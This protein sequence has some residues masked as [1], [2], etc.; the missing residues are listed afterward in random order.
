M[1]KI[2]FTWM[3]FHLLASCGLNAQNVTNVTF[4][5]VGDKAI[6]NYSLDKEADI[7]LY[8]STNE[9]EGWNTSFMNW[10]VYQ[11][12]APA[13]R[14]VKGDVGRR[15]K[16]GQNKQIVW[17]YKEEIS[18]FFGRSEN[19]ITSSFVINDKKW[20]D[21]SLSS[22]QFKVEACPST[23]EPDLVWIDG[24][25]GLGNYWIGR[26]P[27]TIY[28]YS[29]FIKETHYITQAEKQGYAEIW[30]YTKNDF[31]KKE[32]V[33]WKCDES[34]NE[35]DPS[36]YELY[37]VVNVSWED[38]TAYCVWLSEKYNKYYDLPDIR[39]W[40]EACACLVPGSLFFGGFGKLK[41]DGIQERI[42][43]NPNEIGWFD[44]NSSK[45]IHPIGKKRP[46]SLH[47]YDMRG[48]VY[49]WTA[50]PINLETSEAVYTKDKYEELARSNK[51]THYNGIGGSS[52]EPYDD[53]IN[54]LRY[55]SKTAT[56]INIGFRVCMT[57]K[58][59]TSW[60]NYIPS[61]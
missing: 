46:N 34:G 17:A 22:L 55:W 28:E 48:N 47:L 4:K 18:I 53:L 2:F 39:E 15:I 56:G 27:V 9:N 38:A 3:I 11:S 57:P 41:K 35:R 26:Y 37:P 43:G 20:S 31:G 8:V 54:S 6:I 16:P 23:D 44:F 52:F 40:Y 42:G 13:L 49:E 19:G 29:L 58:E 59:N 45:E 60:K 5:I 51:L 50:N 21:S 61:R 25:D 12:T 14:A 32:G 33:T 36:E 1:R 30:D 7:Y 10:S 24:C